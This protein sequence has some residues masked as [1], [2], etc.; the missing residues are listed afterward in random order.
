M[1]PFFPYGRIYTALDRMVLAA[2]RSVP[3]VGDIPKNVGNPRSTTEHQRIVNFN[4]QNGTSYDGRA[5]YD[6][7]DMV[8]GYPAH[9]R[10]NPAAT[11]QLRGSGEQQ[12][13]ERRACV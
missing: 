6:Q 8:Y 5:V 4:S 12:R 2:C 11:F 13:C 7:T 10:G 9:P 3:T 1:T